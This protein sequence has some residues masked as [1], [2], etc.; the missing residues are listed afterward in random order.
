MQLAR[1]LKI[2]L[3]RQQLLVLTHVARQF[4]AES[5]CFAANPSIPLNSIV[6]NNRYM[7]VLVICCDRPLL[8]GLLIPQMQC[9]T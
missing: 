6:L 3:C 7:C 9:Q 8:I 1:H 2:A 4:Q 5:N